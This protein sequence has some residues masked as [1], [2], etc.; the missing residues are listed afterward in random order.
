MIDDGRA[1]GAA[2]MH[3]VEQRVVPNVERRGRSP[4]SVG[5]VIGLLA[6]RVHHGTR[7]PIAGP[8]ADS[9]IG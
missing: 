1:N 6:T 5:V 3:L 2:V 7:T 4:V 9:P 8:L